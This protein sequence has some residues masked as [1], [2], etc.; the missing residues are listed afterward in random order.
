MMFLINPFSRAMRKSQTLIVGACLTASVLLPSTMAN[1]K[2][3]LT[4]TPVTYMLASELTKDTGITTG[5]LPPK[6][7]GISRLPNW[8]TTKGSEVA[9]AASHSATAVVSLGAI[10]H[11]DPLFQ[12]A[13]EGNIKVVEIDASQAISPR[14][15]GVATLRLNDGSTSM[16]AWLNPNN[17]TVMS[18]IVSRDLQRLWPEKAPQI[19]QNQQDLMV[20]VRQLINRQQKALMEANVDAVVLLS[21]ELEDFASGNQLFVVER[22]TKPELEWNDEDKARLVKL[23]A[24][25]PSV[26]LLTTKALSQSMRK[27]VTEQTK[28]IVIDSIDRWGRAGINSE[29]PLQRWEVNI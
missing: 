25:D 21:S 15:Q 2:D 17:L 3:I 23:V 14:A 4:A 10:W 11:Q 6:R 1:A 16:Y 13:R 27:L 18:S 28:V 7:Y 22:L 12:H 24:E 8:F 29:K 9:S 19:K 5:Y 26:T 20:D